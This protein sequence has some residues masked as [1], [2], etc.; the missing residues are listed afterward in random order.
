MMPDA[1]TRGA[2]VNGCNKSRRQLQDPH[3]LRARRHYAVVPAVI[4]AVRPS[5]RAYPAN[6]ASRP[7]SSFARRSALPSRRRWPPSLRLSAGPSRRA[8]LAGLSSPAA[9][10]RHAIAGA[11]SASRLSRPCAPYEWHLAMPGSRTWSPAGLPAAG[12]GVSTAPTGRGSPARMA[13]PGRHAGGP[14][15]FRRKTPAP[16]A[17]FY[18]GSHSPTSSA[19]MRRHAIAD[20]TSA[21]SFSRPCVS[22]DWHFTRPGSRMWLPQ[23]G[24]LRPPERQQH[25]QAWNRLRALQCPAVVPVVLAYGAPCFW[26]GWV[27]GAGRW[28]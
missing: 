3:L 2:A 15:Q 1:I 28:G 8:G 27:E 14:P 13:A 16:R 26:L 17:T 24:Q 23:C 21:S 5:A 11:T 25:Q 10:L 9:T 7:Y 12:A 6:S 4:P 18:R 20:A 22:Y 19:A